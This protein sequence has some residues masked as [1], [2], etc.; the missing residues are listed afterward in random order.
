MEFISFLILAFKAQM[1]SVSF[2]TIDWVFILR[3]ESTSSSIPIDSF[4]DVGRISSHPPKARVYA[5]CFFSWAVCV[6][7]AL[8]TG[9]RI[10][11]EGESSG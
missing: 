5:N 3:N 6:F 4:D 8:L 11:F 1:S 9:K 10:P 2:F 7:K